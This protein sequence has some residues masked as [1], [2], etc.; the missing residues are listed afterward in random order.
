MDKILISDQHASTHVT[1]RKPHAD[2]AIPLLETALHHANFSKLAMQ[3]KSHA[4]VVVT[5]QAVTGLLV[6]RAQKE[7]D[8]LNAAVSKNLSLALPDTLSTSMTNNID[9]SSAYLDRCLRWIAPDEW[10]LTCSLAD[11]FDIETSLR[12]QMGDKACAMV[13]ASGGYTVLRIRGE[14]AQDVMMKS[15]VYDV[16]PVNFPAGK[17][18]NTVMAKAQVT[19]TSLG[20]NDFELIV[21]RSFADYV[22][23][24]LQVA[25]REYGLSVGA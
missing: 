24:W 13:N 5:E 1:E 17:V 19:I 21:R 15:T 18:V 25:S 10:W 8:A 4:G 3:A 2:S 22:W 11:I 23:T 12:Q 14:N 20:S 6:L 16:H 9:E 7:K